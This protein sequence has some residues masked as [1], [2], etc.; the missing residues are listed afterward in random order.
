MVIILE[1]SL[2]TRGYWGCTRRKSAK[3]DKSHE[4]ASLEVPDKPEEK[5]K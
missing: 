5:G 4:E 2:L 1:L 3:F